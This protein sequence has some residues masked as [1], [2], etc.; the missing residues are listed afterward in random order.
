MYR[1][2]D[3]SR[4]AQAWRVAQAHA[5]NAIE[6]VEKDEEIAA[7]VARWDAEGVSDEEQIERLTEMAQAKTFAM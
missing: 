3:N 7:L 2:S 1:E 6:G 5:N 4:E